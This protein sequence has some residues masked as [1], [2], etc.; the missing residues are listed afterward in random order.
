MDKIQYNHS[1]SSIHRAIGVSD[2]FQEKIEVWIK[3]RFVDT[4]AKHDKL[5]KTVEE[6]L[7]DIG[8]ST[9]AEYFYAGIQ[10]KSASLSLEMARERNLIDKINSGEFSEA[11]SEALDPRKIAEYVDEFE[12][13]I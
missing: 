11:L 3:E 13:I 4:R 10:Y 12:E 6:F 1:E 5:T 9:P 8:A 7:N 2:H